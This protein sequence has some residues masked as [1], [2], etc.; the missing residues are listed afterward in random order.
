MAVVETQPYIVSLGNEQKKRINGC[1]EQ[2]ALELRD[3][4]LSN[5][6]TCSSLEEWR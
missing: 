2:V 3:A 4:E 6:F 5:D 1:C